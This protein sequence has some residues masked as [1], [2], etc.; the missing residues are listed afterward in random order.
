MS[1]RKNLI[2]R[3]P[4]SGCLEGRTRFI[5]LAT[6]TLPGVDKARPDPEIAAR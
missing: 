4:Q 2:L 3:R 6:K 5:Q 1:L